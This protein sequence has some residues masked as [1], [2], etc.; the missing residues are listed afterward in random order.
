MSLNT[1]QN[2]TLEMIDLVHWWVTA[3]CY[4][5]LRVF[6]EGDKTIGTTVMLIN[7]L[8]NQRVLKEI[9]YSSCN[10]HKIAL[11][12]WGNHYS[13]TGFGGCGQWCNWP[14]C[15]LVFALCAYFHI[16]NIMN[17]EKM[18]SQCADCVKN[19]VIFTWLANFQTNCSHG[20]Y[21]VPQ[22]YYF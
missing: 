5:L 2:V 4:L 3:G 14:D 21:F 11:V 6:H 22:L 20:Y 7:F 17:L 19:N 13:V 10:F 16:L 9:C 18:S 12:L 15:I 1:R 8:L